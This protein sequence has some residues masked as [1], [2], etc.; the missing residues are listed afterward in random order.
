MNKII[1]N[2][3]YSV[4]YQIITMFLPFIVI[5]YV[6]RVLGAE[7]LGIEAYTLSIVSIFIV[8]GNVGFN[9][10]A[11]RQVATS[12]NEHEK[13]KVEVYSLMLI[14]SIAAVVAVILY[15]FYALN[16]SYT[17]LFMLQLVFFVASTF[18]DFIW[19]FSGKE[20]F[21]EIVVR[22]IFIKL[23]GVILIFIGVKGPS[24]LWIYILINGLVTLIPNLYFFIIVI[25]EI[26]KP[27]KKYFKATII[28]KKILDLI[29]F[30]FMSLIIQVYMNIDRVILGYY[31]LNYELGIYSQ[32]LKTINIILAPITAMGA[33]LLPRMSYL[34]SKNKDDEGEKILLLSTNIIIILS[35]G[36]FFG[37]EAISSQFVPLF[38]GDKFKEF[39]GVFQLGGLLIFTGS[40]SNILVQ[41]IIFPN[42][43]EKNYTYFIFFA[44]VIRVVVVLMLIDSFGIYAAMIAFIVSELCIIVACIQVARKKSYLPSI[45]SVI[46]ISKIFFSGSIMYICIYVIDIGMIL[47]ILA[48]V[49]IY[50]IGLV[51]TKEQI[52]KMIIGKISNR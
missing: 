46:N 33:I 37:L 3:L 44:M 24:D 19:Y 8:F 35:V 50:T 30:F 32:F 15:Y 26:G 20:R 28:K 7:S 14:R 17:F 2:Y 45:F 25:K 16:A 39:I 21:K 9:N 40:M 52:T 42:K 10:Y 41:Q 29:P 5:P 18:F 43:E 13:L 22:N 1:Q 4:G 36:I 49:V 23:I 47:E 38:F 31:K 27:K 12:R 48:G 34:L 11:T 6:T 51:V